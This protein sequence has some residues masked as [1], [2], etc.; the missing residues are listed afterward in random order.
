MSSVRHFRHPSSSLPISHTSD[1][2]ESS[3]HPAEQH[4]SI[5][6]LVEPIFVVVQP[7]VES[8]EDVGNVRAVALAESPKAGVSA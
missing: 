4:R 6:H 2:P 7:D 1:L 3:A 5:A 8:L